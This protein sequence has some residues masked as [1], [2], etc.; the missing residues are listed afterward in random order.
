L[1]SEGSLEKEELDRPQGLEP[2][3]IPVYIQWNYN[4]E[5]FPLLTAYCYFVPSFMRTSGSFLKTPGIYFKG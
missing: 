4:K 3:L 5:H 2:L 1:G